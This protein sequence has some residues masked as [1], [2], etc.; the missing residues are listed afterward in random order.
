M[1]TFDT[2][3]KVD[4]LLKDSFGVTSTDESL[5]WFAET[6]EFYNSYVIGENILID[7]IP[8]EPI[9]NTPVEASSIGLEESDFA[10]Y[11]YNTNDIDNCSIVDD[12]TGVVRR[13]RYLLLES[14]L[15][16]NND[17]RSWTKKSNGSNVLFNSLA[18]NYKKTDVLSPYEY[19]VYK[20]TGGQ[21]PSQI[22]ATTGTWSY[23]TGTGILFFAD[24]EEQTDVS[25]TNPPAMIIYVYIGNRGLSNF[26]TSSSSSSSATATATATTAGSA[27]SLLKDQTITTTTGYRFTENEALVSTDIGAVAGVTLNQSRFD[28]TITGID[29]AETISTISDYTGG[30]KLVT[31]DSSNTSLDLTLRQTVTGCTIVGDTVT[32][33]GTASNIEANDGVIIPPIGAWNIMRPTVDYNGQEWNKINYNVNTTPGAA[34]GWN[35]LGIVSY[36]YHAFRHNIVDSVDDANNTFTLK[37]PNSYNIAGTD[38]LD[39][40]IIKDQSYNVVQPVTFDVPYILENDNLVT[41][42]AV[43]TLTNKTISTLGLLEGSRFKF[44]GSD[45]QIRM[46]NSGNTTHFSYGGN[47]DHYLRSNSN[48]GKV[49]LQDGGGSVGIGTSSPEGQFHIGNFYGGHRFIVRSGKVG[50]GTNNP[51]VPFQ[52]N[53]SVYLPVKGDRGSASDHIHYYNGMHA[54]VGWATAYGITSWTGYSDKH[55]SMYAP[56]GNIV[57]RGLYAAR[58]V[59][60]SSDERIKTNIKEI[61]DDEALK[62]LR[63]LKP[64]TYNYIDYLERGI[65]PVYGFIAQ[66]VREVLPYAVSEGMTLDNV[67][68]N[69]YKW[70]NVTNGT[71]LSFADY[72]ISNNVTIDGIEYDIP[73]VDCTTSKFQRDASNNITITLKNKNGEEITRNVINIIDDKTFEIDVEIEENELATD[74]TIF[75]FGQAVDDFCRLNKS[76]IWTVATAALQEVDRQ[77]QAEKTKV[78]TLETKTATLESQLADVLTRLSALENA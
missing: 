14:T 33:T 78:A 35:V 32:Y 30:Y 44:T 76:A 8:S 43:Q 7:T 25:T 36:T 64:C 65:T 39:I 34:G 58:N 27:G 19:K 40:E 74:G 73:E 28:S 11:L 10:S 2:I 3:E 13:Y 63:L 62:K 66:E 26:T 23:N 69:I 59:H 56:D 5:P 38:S 55:V 49:V 67:I 12:S 9:F 42:N 61:H 51:V 29:L 70:C 48:S 21:S 31:L 6:T 20:T 77:L 15:G 72:D 37:F 60:V 41:E 57:S 45:C 75:V 1:P 54:Y 24:Y 47:G 46:N 71:T 53:W 52:I 22:A 17:G 68:P 16:T 4:I 50:I 18:F